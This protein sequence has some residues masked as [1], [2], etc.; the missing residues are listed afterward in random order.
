MGAQDRRP[1]GAGDRQFL[2]LAQW[3][4]TCRWVVP[5]VNAS[6]LDGPSRSNHRQSELLHRP[7]GGGRLKPLHDEAVIKRCVVAHLSV[8]IRRRQGRDGWLFR[9]TRSVFVAD[10]MESTVS[11]SRIAFNVIPT[12]MSSSTPATLRRME[13]MVEVAEDPRSR[14]P[15]HR[16]LRAGA[17]PLSSAHSEV[18]NLEFEKPI[19]AAAPGRCCREAPGWLVVDKHEDG[20]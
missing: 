7:T 4:A 8:G 13:M 14:H 1:R 5:E 6:A 20:G 2:D 16:G 11:P 18:V 10:P 19:T 12:S 15:G 9:Q 3:T 17:L